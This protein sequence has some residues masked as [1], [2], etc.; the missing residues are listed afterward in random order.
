VARFIQWRAIWPAGNAAQ[1]DLVDVPY[2]P[3]NTAPVVHGITVTSITGM[4]T[5]K[6]TVPNPNLSGAYSITVTDTGEAPAASTNTNAAQAISRQQ[7][8]QTQVTWQADDADGDKLMY[9]IYLRAEGEKDWHL[10]RDHFF[11]TT[12]TLDPD[13]LGD[14][15]YLFRVV[16]SDAPTN[17]TVRARK[18]EL[19]SSAVLVD[20]TPPVV[21]IGTPRRSGDA[22][23]VEV[24][25]TDATSTLRRC[26]YALDA[27]LWQPVEATDGITDSPHEQFHLH[28]DKLSAGEHL[29]VF[30]VYDA[31]NNAGLAKVVLH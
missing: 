21:T 2:L 10:V 17:T 27:G 28:L 11:D 13:V 25:A 4:N 18:G 15:R 29:L 20:N 30:R 24:S 9:A 23:D 1:I 6:A 5:N 16:A 14:G 12:L 26:E 7:T 22:L 19:V 3:Q 8:T 31:A